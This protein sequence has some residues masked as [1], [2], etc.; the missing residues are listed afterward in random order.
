MNLQLLSLSVLAALLLAAVVS[1]LH[2]RRI[3]NALVLYGMVLGLVFQAIAPAGHGLLQGGGLGV[4]A[5]LLGGLAGLV[6]FLPF[7][8]LRLLGAGDVKLMAM[9]GVWL[10]PVSVLQATLWTVFCG[11]LLASVV[12][13]ATG[14]LRPVCRNMLALITPAALR[15][16][17]VTA[18]PRPATT[19]RL[20][21]GVAIAVGSGIEM[22]RLLLST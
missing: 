6:L 22:A 15:T 3:P 12:M 9:V 19:G 5:A 16:A 11:A 2:R 21:Y 10:G 8:A 1:D 4:A 17:S 7:H 18:L 13:L 14:S 20:P